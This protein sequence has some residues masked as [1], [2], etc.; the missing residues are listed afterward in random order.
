MNVNLLSHIKMDHAM[1]QA[2]EQ[3]LFQLHYQPQISLVNGTL[4]GA[5]ALIRW[6]DAE[7]GQVP[8]AQFIPL[9]E[10][11]GFIVTIGNWVLEEAVRQA[12]QWQRAGMP[13]VVSGNVSALQF[14]QTDFVDT[15]AGVLRTAGLP[16]VLLELE[17]TESILIQDAQDA[18]NRLHALAA[19]GLALSIDDFGTGYSSLAYLKKF[20][21]SKLKIDRSFVMG[22]PEDEGDRAIVSATIGMARGLKLKVVAEGVE[23]QAQ[24]DYLASL[25]CESYQGFLCSPG[26]PAAEFEKLMTKLPHTPA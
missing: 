18:M 9:A 11:S 13:V 1:R 24:H 12:V 17:L 4:L 23:T 7:L 10:E 5:E 26:L 22:L 14:Q 2:L 20:P 8:P 16:A 15:V 3:G 25:G 21:I 19:L 6:H